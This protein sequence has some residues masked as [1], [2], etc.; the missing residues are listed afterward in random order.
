MIGPTKFC[1]SVGP[2]SV[3]ILRSHFHHA[4]GELGDLLFSD[5]FIAYTCS[6]TRR[7]MFIHIYLTASRFDFTVSR[8]IVW[9]ASRRYFGRGVSKECARAW[10]V[11]SATDWAT[12]LFP[13][14]TTRTWALTVACFIKEFL[15]TR[16]VPLLFAGCFDWTRSVSPSVQW[17]GD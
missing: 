2:N 3:W 7:C 13:S 4:F 12:I 17:S 8:C 5:C 16:R 9:K 1:L 6:V 14:R 15:C 11:S 10:A